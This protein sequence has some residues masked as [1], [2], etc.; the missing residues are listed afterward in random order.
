VALAFANGGAS[1]KMACKVNPTHTPTVGELAP[2]VSF[3][4]FKGTVIEQ[5]D[6]DIGDLIANTA[7]GAVYRGYWQKEEVAIKEVRL[8][9]VASTDEKLRYAHANY[10][11]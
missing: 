10:D 2:D 9:A 7:V 8:H 11:A 4:E 3:A 1:Q 6:L 5:R